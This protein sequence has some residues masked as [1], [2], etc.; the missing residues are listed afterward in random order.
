MALKIMKR[1]Y[2]LPLYILLAWCI[3]CNTN[4]YKRDVSSIQVDFEINAFEDDMLDLAQNFSDEKR[5]AVLEKYPVFFEVFNEQI[6]GIGNSSD[7]LYRK[8]LTN[9]MNDEYV[10]VMY[11]LTVPVRAQRSDLQKKLHSAFQ[12]YRYYFPENSLPQVCTFIGSIG[13]SISTATV[14][15]A[16]EVVG[17]GADRYLG[18]DNDI[19]KELGIENF[20][21][22]NM[23]PE[24]IPSDVMRAMA[25]SYFPP[26]FGDSFFEEDHLLA[27]MIG[28]GRYMFFVKSMLPMEHDTI[29]WGYSKKQLEFCE[30]SEREF[31]KYFVGNNQLLFSSDRMDIKRFTGDGPF[32]HAFTR[33]SPARIG[34]WVGF[35]IVESFMKNNP[36]VTMH[37]LFAITS[38]QEIM[39][40]AR[41]NP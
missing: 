39:Q 22:K 32:T 29:I 41:Y 26:Q 4:P 24:K 3:S 7:S 12:Y 23:Y 2:F 28:N 35:R 40:R 14:D 13:R 33:E 25:E 5:L 1:F 11:E 34:Q 8:K 38:A 15:T 6:I 31:W 36:D 30:Q 20:T 27:H 18:A 17:I 21:R 16:T 10:K 9:Y 37:D 19:Y